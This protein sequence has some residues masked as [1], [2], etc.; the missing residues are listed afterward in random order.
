[1][2]GSV[3]DIERVNENEKNNNPDLIKLDLTKP[4]YKCTYAKLFF[5]KQKFD[6]FSLDDTE[7][8][9]KRIN[10]FLNTLKR[11]KIK[12][13]FL[14]IIY[15][16]KDREIIKKNLSVFPIYILFLLI[17]T[18][19]F[20]KI[21]DIDTINLIIKQLQ[22]Y[23]P[24]IGSMVTFYFTN[25]QIR[26]K[27][28]DKIKVW[29]KDENILKKFEKYFS[30]YE[31]AIAL[32][33]QITKGGNLSLVKDED[34]Q[35]ESST[36]FSK[37]T[38]DFTKERPLTNREVN[39]EKTKFFSDIPSFLTEKSTS[40]FHSESRKDIPEY[41]RKKQKYNIYGQRD[42]GNYYNVGTQKSLSPNNSKPKSSSNLIKDISSS[43]ESFQK[44][45]QI[46]SYSSS[47]KNSDLGNKQVTTSSTRFQSGKENH[48]Q[49]NTIK[50]TEP[51]LLSERLAKLI[52]KNNSSQVSYSLK[53]Q[54]VRREVILV[55]AE[56]EETK[57][58]RR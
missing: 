42:F 18:F 56:E 14:S 35:S 26:F 55:K 8:S 25:E 5:D 28:L 33:N 29:L 4:I 7:K 16:F 48:E 58:R 19:N 38:T 43:D 10:S 31:K 17:G 13:I 41:L 47:Y 57:S 11:R 49:G 30:D 51:I 50:I 54:P 37:K 23:L 15:I 27:N 40:S 6:Y 45:M 3:I 46:P 39:D 22:F 32:E 34:K 21:I 12:N 53:K 9:K 36:S 1:M 20:D 52:D 24:I 44:Q 2:K